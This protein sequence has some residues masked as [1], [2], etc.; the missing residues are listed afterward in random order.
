MTEQRVGRLPAE[1][2][3]ASCDP[4]T[5]LVDELTPW[6]DPWEASRQLAHLPHLLF[7][8]SA[9]S[10]PTRGRY[11]FVTADPFDW[12]WARGRQLIDAYNGSY[13]GDPFAVLA[14]KL[15][16]WRTKTVAGLPPVSYTHLTLPTIL[17]V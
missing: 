14:R 17:R 1:S 6:L 3:S 16:D 12:L 5:P 15:A 8:E 4:V 10:H 2:R 13:K 9:A 11:S 7:L